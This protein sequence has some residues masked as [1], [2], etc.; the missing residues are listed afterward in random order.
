MCVCVSVCLSVCLSVSVCLYIPVCVVTSRSC[1]LHDMTL[2]HSLSVPVH[3]PCTVMWLSQNE[4]HHLARPLICRSLRYGSPVDTGESPL[5]SST[6]AA[7]WYDMASQ[8][9]L[10]PSVSELSCMV[11]QDNSPLDQPWCWRS[12]C[13]R[14]MRLVKFVC[15]VIVRRQYCSGLYGSSGQKHSVC[16]T[17]QMAIST[18]FSILGAAN[19]V[20]CVWF[21]WTQTFSLYDRANVSVH[22]FFCTV[23]RHYCSVCLVPVDTSI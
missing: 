6:F 20:L 23:R 8:H 9:H 15:T 3:G 1:R 13:W 16:M 17:E 18:S 21:Q 11:W 5:G 4:V 14:W 12:G 10:V 19:I 22:R 7:V 2:R